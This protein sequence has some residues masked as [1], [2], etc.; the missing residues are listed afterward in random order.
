M[1]RLF[2]LIVVLGTVALVSP[3]ADTARAGRP[4]HAARQ[5]KTAAPPHLTIQPGRPGSTRQTPATRYA[6]G[7]FGVKPRHHCVRHFGYLRDF[8][9]WTAR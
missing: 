9:Q 8:T 6:Y 5:N 4:D 3:G 1:R 2:M 7:W